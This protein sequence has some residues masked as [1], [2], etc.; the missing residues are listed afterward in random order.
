MTDKREVKKCPFCGEEILATA[1]KCKHC[2]SF[3]EDEPVKNPQSS[4]AADTRQV[5]KTPPPPMPPVKPPSARPAPPPPPAA[6][7]NLNVN[8]TT[9]SAPIPGPSF[10]EST[11]PIK[12]DGKFDE[13]PKAPLGK[14]VIAYI[15]DSLIAGLPMLIAIILVV[16]DQAY[17]DPLSLLTEGNPLYY[18]AIVWLLIYMLLRDSFGSGQSWGKKIQGLMVV[19]LA[20]NEPCSKGKSVLRNGIALLIG[21]IIGLIPVINTLAG[22]VDPI[23]AMAH[24]KG[25]RVGDMIAKTQVIEVSAHRR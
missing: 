12:P 7:Q 16:S 2:H 21:F 18:V 5:P 19:N 13:Y 3:I 9:A 24:P 20:D 15:V 17:I 6:Q 23:I 10:P 14:R 11:S 25:H 1:K 22:I 8:R 4:I